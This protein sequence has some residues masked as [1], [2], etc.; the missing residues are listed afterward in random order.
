MYSKNHLGIDFEEDYT[1]K[2][3]N[4][5]KM[6]KK[7]I[8]LVHLDNTALYNVFLF[9][10]GS[11]NNIDANDP[12][13]RE[14]LLDDLRT[15]LKLPQVSSRIS[16]SATQKSLSDRNA[17]A[18]KRVDYSSTA[19]SQRPQAITIPSSFSTKPGDYS[20]SLQSVG[21][22]HLT[23]KFLSSLPGITP[24]LANDYIKLAP[25]NV[26]RNV[27]EQ[28]AQRIVATIEQ[29]GGRAV[30]VEESK[31]ESKP[32]P[33]A[34]NK[35]MA[36]SK[37]GQKRTSSSHSKGKEYS[38][39]LQSAPNLG[40][41]GRI[42]SLLSGSSW[43]L[44]LLNLPLVIH[45]TTSYENAMKWKKDWNSSAQRLRLFNP[46]AVGN[47]ENEYANCSII[48]VIHSLFLE[49]LFCLVIISFALR[50][51]L[52]QVVILLSPVGRIFLRMDN[53]DSKWAN[54]ILYFPRNP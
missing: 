18:S 16:P 28:D 26:I 41:V 5:A 9:N 33:V 38:V 51:L 15:I 48:K 10:F 11:K 8:I 4:Y 34:T 30:A 31:P 45:K 17:S 36:S 42:L 6:T 19:R 54:A 25:L 39:V 24:E 21:D 46:A 23:L 32:F 52:S 47:R 3:L 40:S 35:S 13:Q 29:L 50:T 20:V 53:A 12:V 27:C 1:I 37:T 2:E 7:P 44:N 14:K 49:L 43:S 22:K